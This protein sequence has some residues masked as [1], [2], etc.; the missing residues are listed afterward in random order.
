MRR[1]HNC[2]QSVRLLLALLESLSK[3]SLIYKLKLTSVSKQVNKRD[4]V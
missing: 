2:Y 3:I 4:D 1:M